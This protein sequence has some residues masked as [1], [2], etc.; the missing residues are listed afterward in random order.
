VLDESV[1][2]VLKEGLARL[3]LADRALSEAL[4]NYLA[5]LEKFNP[6]YKLVKAADTRELVVRHILDSLAPLSLIKRLLPERPEPCR[7]ADIGSGP[8]LPG[9]PLSLALSGTRWTLVE[10]MAR[11]VGFLRSTTALLALSTVTVYEGQAE[12]A[13][14]ANKFDFVT[15]RAF[16]P[17]TPVLAATLKHLLAPEGV[18][19]LYK[20]TEQKTHAE[21]TAAGLVG[22]KLIPY[23]VPFLDEER[24]LAVVP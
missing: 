22:V 15:C 14:L 23:T 7:C 11:R 21:I 4:E 5:E 16:A 17:L 18:I 12:D 3:G 19:A 2:T 20:G 9:V 8:G 13:A 10:R 6:I 24:Y 1:R